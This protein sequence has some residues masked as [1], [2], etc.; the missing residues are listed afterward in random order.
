[1]RWLK[2]TISLLLVLAAVAVVIATVLSEHSDDYG[3]V[4][5]PQGGAVSLPE[6]R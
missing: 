6:G 2:N 4:T 1:M 5:L 3:V